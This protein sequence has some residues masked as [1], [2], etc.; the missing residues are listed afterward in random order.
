MQLLR[1]SAS[2]SSMPAQSPTW[3]C[4]SIRGAISTASYRNSEAGIG[5]PVDREARPPPPLSVN[6]PDKPAVDEIVVPAVVL[7]APLFDPH[8]D[9]A[10]TVCDW[11]RDWP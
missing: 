2:H 3:I 11:L 7:Q 4:Q 1:S 10:T 8:G 5:E 9:V 6:A